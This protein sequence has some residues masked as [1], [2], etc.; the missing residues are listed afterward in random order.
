MRIRKSSLEAWK[1][2]RA[3]VLE[4]ADRGGAETGA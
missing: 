2:A 4:C 1:P 3:D